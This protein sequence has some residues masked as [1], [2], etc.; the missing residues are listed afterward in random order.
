MIIYTFDHYSRSDADI[1]S[2][3]GYIEPVDKSK[4]IERE[5][6]SSIWTDGKTDLVAW[7]VSHCETPSLRERYAAQLMKHI[8]VHVYGQCGNLSLGQSTRDV[9]KL[10]RRYKFYLAFENSLCPEYA[11]EK[12]WNTLNADTVPVVLGMADYKKILPKG[13]YIDIRDFQSAES[14]A[15][16][17]KY[18]DGNDRAYEKYFEWKNNY[19]IKH[20]YEYYCKLCDYLHKNPRPKKT[21]SDLYSWL[22]ICSEPKDFYKDIDDITL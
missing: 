6:D 12:V 17:L 10:K 18:L 2:G 16:Y 9:T 4:N 13:S 8:P 15:K 14:L 7:V 20:H 22:N 21:Y 5:S 19:V 1:I 11:T 3:Y